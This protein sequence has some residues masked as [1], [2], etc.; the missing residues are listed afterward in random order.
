MGSF[1]SEGDRERLGC[2]LDIRAVAS[3]GHAEEK[4]VASFNPWIETSG[5]ENGS[6]KYSAHGVRSQR[7]KVELRSCRQ[8]ESLASFGQRVWVGDP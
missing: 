4:G 2:R 6:S 1:Q 3:K 8:G 7:A 5:E